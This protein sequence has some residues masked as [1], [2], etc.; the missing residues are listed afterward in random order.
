[1]SR[2]FNE[3]VAHTDSRT[4]ESGKCDRSECCTE[5]DLPHLH[6]NASSLYFTMDEFGRPVEKE[7]VVMLVPH[8]GAGFEETLVFTSLEK[9]KRVWSILETRD[10][11]EF[12][13]LTFDVDLDA[14]VY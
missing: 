8:H 10:C 6:L 14:W 9:A 12:R 7:Q 3:V 13:Q 2:N 4:H 1:M 5:L 11:V